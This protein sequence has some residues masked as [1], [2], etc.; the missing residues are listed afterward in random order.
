MY[1]QFK[2]LLGWADREHKKT[3]EKNLLEVIL[4]VFA[5][6]KGLRFVSMARESCEINPIIL[7]WKKTILAP[8][9]DAIPCLC[10]TRAHKTDNLWLSAAGRQGC[11]SLQSGPDLLSWRQNPS[12]DRRAVWRETMQI[13]YLGQPGCILTGLNI[14][15]WGRKG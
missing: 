2:L 8:A 12:S 10:S 1:L 15:L 5:D 4:L 3:G 13:P 14:P 6:T 11:T 9:A 7:S